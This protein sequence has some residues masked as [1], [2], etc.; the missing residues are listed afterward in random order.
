MMQGPA[1]PGMERC[2]G[3]VKAGMN[4]CGNASHNCSG[5]A[6]T[7]RDAQEWVYMPS[8]LCNRIEGGKTSTDK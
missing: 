4:D 3:V 5:K 2:F 1:I 8:G 7:A 6:K